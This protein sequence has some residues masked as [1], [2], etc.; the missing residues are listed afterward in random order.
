M[1][2]KKKII[3]MAKLYYKKEEMDFSSGFPI[4]PECKNHKQGK[5]MEVYDCKNLFVIERDKEGRISEQGQCC[6][7]SEEHGKRTN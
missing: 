4:C 2:Y 1:G 7:Y 6:C 5:P 3:K